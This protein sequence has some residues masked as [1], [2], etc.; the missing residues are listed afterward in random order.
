M[1]G[2]SN[3]TSEASIT[4]SFGLES[5]SDGERNGDSLEVLWTSY[6]LHLQTV[7]RI[8]SAIPSHHPAT[9]KQEREP[10]TLGL[11]V[12]HGGDKLTRS[13]KTPLLLS[14]FTRVLQ[15]HYI[16]PMIVHGFL[17]MRECAPQVSIAISIY[18]S[19]YHYC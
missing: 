14:T 3:E 10:V 11:S 4:S 16:L 6:N 15:Y 5:D 12:R 7:A 8:H 17:A 9:S 1:V 13:R 19:I 2:N 18:L